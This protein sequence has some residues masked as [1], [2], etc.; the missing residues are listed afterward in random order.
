MRKSALLILFA[1]LPASASTIYQ[2]R[3]TGTFDS[4]AIAGT[5]NN[6]GQSATQSLAGVKLRGSINFD[7]N[8]LPPPA[9]NSF[10]ETLFDILSDTPRYI[11]AASFS[12]DIPPSFPNSSLF[13]SGPYNMEPIPAP[14][15]GTNLA[16]PSIRQDLAVLES[17][18]F[19]RTAFAATNHWSNPVF[20]S[21]FHDV[22]WALNAQGLPTVPYNPAT[23]QFVPFS[24]TPSF[25]SG[26]VR[27]QTSRVVNDPT[28]GVL[29][30]VENTFVSGSFKADNVTGE[31][32]T[33]EPATLWLSPLALALV[34]LKR[35]T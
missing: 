3:F 23:G 6:N 11:V 8:Q 1:L 5:F 32:L 33:P 29:G 2:L 10:G 25:S 28:Q 24:G 13:D 21:F 22:L 14:P 7:V 34:F 20:N 35:K 30:F 18:N 19:V 12:V 27:Y 9:T 31:I 4:S 17:I 15:D 26:F 16:T